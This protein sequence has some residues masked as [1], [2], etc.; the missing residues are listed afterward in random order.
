MSNEEG[1]FGNLPFNLAGEN[2]IPQNIEKSY[3]GFIS[4]FNASICF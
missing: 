4:G 2:K 3:L 1:K